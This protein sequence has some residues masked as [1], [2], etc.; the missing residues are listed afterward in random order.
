MADTPNSRRNLWRAVIRQAMEDATRFGQGDS[1]YAREVRRDRETA[2]AWLTK[3]SADFNEVCELADFEPD[4]VRKE[5]VALIAEA[6]TR[7]AAGLRARPRKTKPKSEVQRYEFQGERLTIPEWSKRT[8][9]SAPTLRGR[10][11]TGW[12]LELALTKPAVV[13]AFGQPHAHRE[14]KRITF[15][16]KSLSVRE[17]AEA[18]GINAKTLH[19][20]LE[21]RWPVS[22]ALTAP[23]RSRPRE[24]VPA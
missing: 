10:L 15:E 17:W 16:G 20:R 23:A 13:G 18:T 24:T 11:N 19:A 9:I 4:Q 6:D 1:D 8:G 14:A 12:P 3:P 2:R 7:V 5:A 21:A 22:R